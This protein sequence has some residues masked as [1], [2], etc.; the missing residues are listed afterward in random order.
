MLA[1]PVGLLASAILVV[2][3]VRDL[4]TDRRAGK[5]TLAVRLGRER[6]RT[7]YAGDARAGVPHGA[8]AVGARLALAVAAARRGWR[9]R[10]PCRS[11]ARCARGPTGRRSTARWRGRGS[12]S[13]RSACCS[14]PAC[15]RAERGCRSLEV[16]PVRLRLRAPLRT[17]W[18]ELAERE[19]LRV[20]LR[21]GDGDSGLGEAAPLEPYDGVPLGA[22]SRRRWTPTR[23]CCATRRAGAEP[24]ELLAA[25]AAERPL[26]QALA[27]IDLALWDRAGRRTGRPVAHLLAAGAATAVP[28]NAT[29]GA[30]DRAGAAA[31]GRGGRGGGL[32]LREGQGR[33]SATTRAGSPRCARR[34]GRTWRSASTPTARGSSPEEALANLR[35]LAPTG[36]EYAEEPVHGIDGARRGA[37]GLARAGGDGRDGGG[38]GAPRAR[39]RPTRSASRSPAAAGSPGCCATRRRRARRAARS[40]SPRR[41]TG[42]WGSRRGCTRRPRWRPRGRAAVRARDARDVRGARRRARAARRRDRG[43]GGSGPALSVASPG[44]SS[45]S[46]DE[47]D[48]ARVRAARRARP[49][50]RGARR[51]RRP[52]T[53]WTRASRSR[54]AI[55]SAIARNF[56]VALPHDELDGHRQ[57]AQ[58]VPQR[59]ASR[60]VPRPRSAAAR[61]GAVL[62]RRSASACSAIPRGIPANSGCAAHSRAKASTPIASIRSA[63]ASSAAAALLALGRVGEP[64]ARADE[65]EPPDPGADRERGVQR[66]PAAHRVA[67]ERERRVGERAQVGVAGGERGGAAPGELAVA[68]QVRRDGA[69]ACP[70]HVAH[71]LPAPARLGEAVEQDQVRVH[72]RER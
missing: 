29:I 13:S 56:V 18:G 10:S 2:N 49:A 9:S 46:M 38:A 58:P 30:E 51:A 67:R 14:R 39:A 12:S 37:G 3:N 7:L 69:V 32:R 36:I 11:S 27:A 31:A 16:V 43:A 68:G 28:V 45:P 59:A 60:P 65:H 54:S 64:R 8:A 47:V 40:T 66:D 48:P 53:T 33:A 15:S 1:V 41:S 44:S 61:P 70:E 26:P 5:R 55:R 42:R 24:G 57:L 72:P 63:S 25:C 22:R 21:W 6:V 34:P 17:A 62:R 35:A 19:L 20:R 52:A 50:A 4:E 23:R 71:R